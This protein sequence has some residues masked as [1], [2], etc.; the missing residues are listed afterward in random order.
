VRC[1]FHHDKTPSAWWNPKKE[2]FYCP[3][4]NLGL[5]LHQM[6]SRLHLEMDEVAPS[7]RE[8]PDFDLTMEVLAMPRGVMLYHPYYAERG[9]SAETIEFYGVQW[10]MYPL[11]GTLF[12]FVN[13][14]GKTQGCMVRYLNPE[15]AGTRYNIH[16]KPT[17]LWP[18]VQL[19]GCREGKVVLITEGPWSAMR[20]HQFIKTRFDVQAYIF[21]TMG[22][23]A[24]EG[25]LDVTRHLRPV[26]LYDGDTAGQNACRKMKSLGAEHAFTLS[27]SPDDMS[28]IH[29]Y[30]LFERL[31]EKCPE[32]TDI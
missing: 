22:A 13:L 15:E 2:L 21:S 5:N 12:P 16:G 19:K 25:L 8:V 28:E 6:Q 24:N 29:M 27:V 1:P 26:F 11:Q 18:L 4:C 20:L 30:Q 7:E 31:M 3:V 17:P 10:T 23:K 9:I 32:L 14:R